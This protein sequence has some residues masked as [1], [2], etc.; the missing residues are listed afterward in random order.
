MESWKLA[1][2]S[3]L[4]V[5]IAACSGSGDLNSATA[6]LDPVAREG[7]G[8]V[9]V[10]SGQIALDGAQGEFNFSIEL[11]A[12]W[13]VTERFTADPSHGAAGQI[14]NAGG[15]VV[16]YEAL[17]GPPELPINVQRRPHLVTQDRN[18]GVETTV[19]EPAPDAMGAG[20]QTGILFADLPGTPDRVSTLPLVLS[21]LPGRPEVQHLVLDLAR[22]ARFAPPPNP[23]SSPRPA[24]TPAPDW[25]RVNARNGLA[26]TANFSL[27]LP[28]G[29]TVEESIGIDTLTGSIQG[30]GIEI[31]YDFGE[32]A[33]SPEAA[34]TGIFHWQEDADGEVI[35][36]FRPTDEPN[37]V[38]YLFGT[39]AYFP[40]LPGRGA[41]SK[42]FPLYIAAAG[43]DESQQETVL[44]ILRTIRNAELDKAR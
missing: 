2:A 20:Y 9:V 17:S 27:L 21:S 41:D 5:L 11:P 10:R 35:H 23:A 30:N 33:G 6:E 34:Q 4:F 18:S 24:V 8:R 16:Q 3:L 42:R 13:W 25:T 32:I 22:T 36:L 28:P 7:P 44:A 38:E 15:P 29:W 19:F 26:F 37:H 1:T 14:W 43:L 40:L 31:Y 39:G 12:G